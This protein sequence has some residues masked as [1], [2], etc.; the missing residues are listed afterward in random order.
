MQASSPDYGIAITEYVNIKNMNAYLE[1]V[2]SCNG[3]FIQ[4]PMSFKANK[5]VYNILCVVGFDSNEDYSRF[6]HAWSRINT[7]ILEVDNRGWFG[8]KFNNLKVFF[9]SL[10]G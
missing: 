6:S 8:T 4:N 2:V 1:L 7:P 10:I 9:N 5:E 3:R